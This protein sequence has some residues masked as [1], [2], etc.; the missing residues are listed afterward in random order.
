MLPSQ[1]SESR[2]QSGAQGSLVVVVTSF[3]GLFTVAHFLF[4]ITEVI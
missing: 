3:F 4:I 2:C 1:T